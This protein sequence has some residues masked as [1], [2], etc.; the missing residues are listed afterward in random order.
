[1]NKL[2]Y[3]YAFLLLGTA[4]SHAQTEKIKGS[5]EV[6]ITQTYVDDFESL[7]IKS[8]FEVKIVFNSKSSV[9]IEADDN[10]HDAINIEVI[11]GT[12]TLSATKQITSKKKLQITINYTGTLRV[13]EL[14]DNAELRSL[15]S[16]E[17]NTVSL[18]TTDESRAYLNIKATTFQLTATGKSKSRLNIVADTTSF[19]LSDNS[20]LEALVTGTSSVFDI[21]QRANATIEG[22]SKISKLRLDNSG[23]FSGKG[24]TI[25]NANL[26]I[27]STSD[28]TIRITKELH[29]EASGTTEIYVYG[30]PKIH[31]KTFT[32]SAKL[33][34]KEL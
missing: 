19:I 25:E 6:T 23:V 7:I 31:L 2:I 26:F 13:I 4:A 34:K 8:D 18:K 16:M 5:R 22:S 14:Q 11:E 32:G 15:T 10:L 27:E 3:I 20:K 12:L 33:Q 9:E 28:A 24:Y 17:L 29:L 21:Y 1:M 30:E